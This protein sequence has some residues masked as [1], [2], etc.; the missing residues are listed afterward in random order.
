MEDNGGIDRPS[1]PSV[2]Y[3]FHSPQIKCF[4]E[5]SPFDFLD[6]RKITKLCQYQ[7]ISQPYAIKNTNTPERAPNL[8]IIKNEHHF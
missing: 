3:L 5:P 8:S 6:E 4:S 2:F 7:K 1:L